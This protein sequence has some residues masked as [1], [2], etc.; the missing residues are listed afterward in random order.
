MPTDFDNLIRHSKP[1]V[2]PTARERVLGYAL[3][4]VKEAGGAAASTHAPFRMLARVAALIMLAVGAGV[5][6]AFVSQPERVDTIVDFNAQVNELRTR[7]EAAEAEAAKVEDMQAQV[8]ALETER[9]DALRGLVLGVATAREQRRMEEWRER[10]IEYVREHTKRAADATIERLRGEVNLTAEQEAEVRAL[11]DEA[12]KEAEGLIGNFY[13]RGRHHSAHREF[14]KLAEATDMK[15]NALLSEQQRRQ[16][17]EGLVSSRP[18]DWGPSS[19][20]RDGTDYEVY[21][22]WMSVSRE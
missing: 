17:G 13:G 2:P 5:V 18:E 12:G 14:E 8:A 4:G 9:E 19:D 7:V 16:V 6:S 20:F 10:H 1:A 11:L 22:N 3:S 21:M 15:L